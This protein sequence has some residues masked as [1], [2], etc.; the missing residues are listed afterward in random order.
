M[1]NKYTCIVMSIVVN[2]VIL[3]SIWTA[4]FTTNV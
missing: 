1:Y 2:I 4:G 3:T